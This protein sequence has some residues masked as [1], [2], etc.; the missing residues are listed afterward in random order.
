MFLKFLALRQPLG[1]RGNHKTRMTP[2]TKFRV[3][4]RHYDV[5]IGYAAVGNPSLGAVEYPLVGGFVIHRSR[6]H[7]RDI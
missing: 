2:T 5:H 6:P 3:D 1:V 4:D 7:R